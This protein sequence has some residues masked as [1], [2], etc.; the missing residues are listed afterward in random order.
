MDNPDEVTGVA[1]ITVVKFEPSILD[2]WILV[3]VIHPLGIEATRTALNP[4]DDVAF[5]EQ[6]LGQ[7][8]T[9]LAGDSRDEGDFWSGV[10][11]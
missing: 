5:L 2:M 9:I 8:R 4:M 10:M 7:V 1:Q 6:E 11:S 3:N